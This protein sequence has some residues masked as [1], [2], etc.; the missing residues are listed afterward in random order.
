MNNQ[1]FY[2]GTVT[3]DELNLVDDRE[4]LF[5]YR[6]KAY[7]YKLV[8]EEDQLVIYDTCDRH[9]PFAYEN[10][11][12]LQHLVNAMASI[13]DIRERAQQQETAIL[14]KIKCQQ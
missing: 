4:S 14:K 9:M 5:Y 7:W 6:N 1:I 11:R 12:E 2:F 3:S 10:L 13:V 8:A